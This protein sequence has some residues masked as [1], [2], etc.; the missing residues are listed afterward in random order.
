M[1]ENYQKTTLFVCRFLKKLP[2]LCCIFK[3]DQTLISEKL[4]VRP[5]RINITFLKISPFPWPYTFYTSVFL[6]PVC[7]ACIRDTWFVFQG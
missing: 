3:T 1:A 6:G 7:S 5:G 2:F 4:A